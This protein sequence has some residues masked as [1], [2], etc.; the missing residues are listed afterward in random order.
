MDPAA[1]VLYSVLALLWLIP[2]AVVALRRAWSKRVIVVGLGLAATFAIVM[3]ARDEDGWF[4]FW[5]LMAL[6]LF[7]VW[8]LGASFGVGIASWRARLRRLRAEQQ[9]I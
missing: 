1:I 2:C 6:L 3:G 8:C 9:P 5:A 4:L 7:A